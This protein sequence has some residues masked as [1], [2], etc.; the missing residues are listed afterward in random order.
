MPGPWITDAE[1]KQ[2]IADALTKDVTL[3]P[4]KWDRFKTQANLDAVA[5]IMSRLLA[6][7]FTSAQIDAWDSRA[8]FN[9]VLARYHALSAG[10]SLQEYDLEQI[11][12]DY[13]QRIKELD[14]AVTL[15][16]NGVM[17]APGISDDDPAAG[18]ATGAIDDS[19]YRINMNTVL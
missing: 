16:I 13:D 18:V 3:M 15:M 5:D 10:A 11:R 14:T 2:L 12:K 7:G 19:Q 8:T 17:Q 9:R 6:K 1:V 4:T